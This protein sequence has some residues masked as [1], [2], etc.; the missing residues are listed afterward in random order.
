M[1]F[2]TDR[3]FAT[4]ITLDD[5]FHIVQPGSAAGNS[6]KVTFNQLKTLLSGPFGIANSTGVYTYYN[7]LQLAINAASSGQTVEVFTDYTE[8]GNV[9][10]NLKNGV[11]INFN[12]HT[13]TLDFSGST[14]AFSDNGIAVNC[15]LL[16]GIIVRRGA[17][18]GPSG[19]ANSNLC[20]YLTSSSN[21]ETDCT[22]KSLRGNTTSLNTSSSI[23]GGKY[24][25]VSGNATS[26]V[27]VING[28]FSSAHVEVETTTNTGNFYLIQTSGGTVNSCNVYSKV[29]S[30]SLGA[31]SIRG[32][33]C[34]SG[35]TINNCTSITPG[36]S[37]FI[38][39]NSTI[40]NSYCYSD[41]NT[42]VNVW[43][44]SKMNNTTAIS[45][46]GS[47]S[48]ALNGDGEISNSTVY[49]FAG[50]GIQIT[51]TGNQ[52]SNSFIYSNSQG[53]VVLG[54]GFINNSCAYSLTSQGFSTSSGPRDVTIKNCTSTS[55]AS[56]SI[57]N[58]SS[59][60]TTITNTVAESLWNNAAGHSIVIGSN[61]S[62]HTIAFCHLITSNTTAN[63]INGNNNGGVKYVNNVFDGMTTPVF[64][65]T[66]LTTNVGDTRGN[67]QT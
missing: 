20:L 12:G 7:T 15:G 36:L 25:S 49:S 48:I 59:T 42:S 41:L 29:P 9:S 3:A 38:N 4:N 57:V 27:V 55:L 37:A 62:G 58:N 6:Y 52:V 53:I 26:S 51:L 13:Y 44:N 43:N 8:T 56:T 61:Y 33:L 64:N 67:I 1:V 40:N 65:I 23:I 24:Y 21:I 60:A 11:D 34:E 45:N 63:A 35:G 39:N 19:S 5:V 16:N 2:L 22:F 30:G 31:V 18:G 17:N 66:Q 32:I 28:L 50:Q 10:I 47:I 46:S 54:G 14:N